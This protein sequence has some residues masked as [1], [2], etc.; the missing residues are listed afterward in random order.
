MGLFSN[1]FKESRKIT[2]PVAAYPKTVRQ[3]LNIQ[4]A[5][6]N[7]IFQI[8]KQKDGQ[9][10]D[11][12]YLFEDINYKDKDDEDKKGILL[13]IMQWLKSMHVQFKIE[14]VSEYQNVNEFL[15]ELCGGIDQ[16]TYPEHAKGLK[17]WIK[18]KAQEGNP[19][20][21][22]LRYLIVTCTAKTYEDAKIQFNILD[23][24]L[25]QY[26]LKWNSRLHVLDA[27]QRLRSLHAFFHPKEGCPFNRARLRDGSWKNDILPT[28]IESFSNFLIFDH[29]QRYVSVLYA[30]DYANSLD[31]GKVVSGFANLPFPLHITMD[32]APIDREV[33]K[34]KLNN[35]YMNNEKAITQELELRQRRNQYALGTSYAKERRKEELEAYKDQI[36]DNDEGCLFLGF[37]VVVTAESEKELERRINE[38]KAVGRGNG[39]YLEIYYHRQLKALNTALP[40]G[41]R[42]VN[43]MRSL[44]TSSA[45]AF[46]PYYAMDLQGRGMVYGINRRTK[47]LLCGDRKSLKS[48][49]GIIIG[50]TGSGKSVFIKMT[51]LLQS[52]LGMPNDD[53]TIIDPQNEYEETCL[54]MG[55]AYY[56]LTPKSDLHIN[57]MEIPE[58]VFYAEEQK[59]REQF[60]A[61]VTD[62]AISFCVAIMTNILVTQEHYSIIGRCI[63][64]VYKEFYAQKTLIRQPTLKEFR[65]ELKREMNR[66]D[67]DQDLT[68]IRQMYNSLEEFTEG[69]FDMFAHPSNI[70]SR[71]RLVGFGL[72]NVSEKM[73]EPVMVTIMFFLSSRMSHNQKLQKATHLII[74]ESQVV[75]EHKSSAD[76]LLKAVETYRK[77]GGICTMCLQNM[78]RAIENPELRD[79]FSNCDFK[80]F[81]D[82]GGVDAKTIAQIQEFSTQEYES[83]STSVPGYGV[84]VW[85]KQVFL[86]DARIAKENLL[87]QKFSTNFHEKAEQNAEQKKVQSLPEEPEKPKKTLARAEEIS[88][89]PWMETYIPKIQMLAKL[90]TITKEELMRT[91]GLT[92]IQAERILQYMVSRS[93][94]AKERTGKKTSYKA[95][96]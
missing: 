45:V 13:S 26:F 60:V 76:M 63:R 53:L 16:T 92:E 93:M 30:K 72:K 86:L 33:L 12:C 35:A 43:V 74:D 9:L 28:S 73:W 11:R 8:G 48:P 81:L 69:S 7:G 78:T 49:H 89:E 64:N 18:E 65:E 79:M 36:D 62:W 66:V 61:D 44:L 58:E 6:E 42:Q 27:E 17:S 15:E 84:L 34:N 5:Y 47:R 3:S 14:L 54:E 23:T 55:G 31:D 4:Q 96:A 88:V 82:Q 24:E 20:I 38:V 95:S 2:D 52:L 68:L 39:V 83:L 91:F 77:F 59:E 37:L 25:H 46:Q 90:I 1:P 41:G 29:D 19:E 75:C 10:Y 51:E 57:A 40:F 56:D 67:N 21:R 87:Y 32:Y 70:N 71:K 80:V 85:E 22:Q 50:H 94:L